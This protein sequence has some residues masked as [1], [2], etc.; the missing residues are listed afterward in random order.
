LSTDEP[1][2]TEPDASDED[3]N[4]LP[5][6]DTEGYTFPDI[7]PLSV[8]RPVFDDPQN[9]SVGTEDAPTGTGF[10]DMIERAVADENTNVHSGT[11]SL[12]LPEVPSSEDL[13]GPLGGT[14]ELFVTGSIELPKSIGETGGHSRLQESIEQ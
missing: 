4:E 14:G 3:V 12:I 2:A 9:R 6:T 8:D 10:D 13:S 5:D 1:D 11:S 7:Q